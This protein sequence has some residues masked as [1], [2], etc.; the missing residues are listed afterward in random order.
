MRPNLRRER[1]EQVVRERE[2]VTV[3]ALAE[4]LGTSRETIRRD[5]TELAERGRVRKIH[6]GATL[7]EPRLSD[8]EGEGSFQARLLQNAEAKRAIARRTIE[9]FQAG[10]TLFVDTGTTTLWFAEEL[11]S[12]T[13]LTVITNSAAIAGL[14]ARGPSNSTFLIGGEYRADGTENLG[15][16]AIEQISQFH[17]V[18]AV[19]AVGSVETVGILDFD[20]REA[21][22][23]RAMIA[24][25]RTITVL[26]DA[27]KFGRGGLIK[28]APLDAIARVVTDADPPAEIAAALRT[29]GTEVIKA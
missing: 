28:V 20:V 29:A 7:A 4:L 6:G 10:D 27:S 11:A 1:I 22:I 17:A 2:R 9:L 15:P 13:G 23:A 19:L 26:A 25:A 3:D 24:Q 14:A 12:A 18:H 5:L 21:D 8:V 16:L